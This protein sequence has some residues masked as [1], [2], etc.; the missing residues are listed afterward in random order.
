MASMTVEEREAF[1][2]EVRVGVLAIEHAGQGPLAV[3]IWYLVKD[4]AVLLLMDEQSLKARLVRAAGQATLTVQQE[5]P[6]YKYVSVEGP[7]T[8]EP[9]AKD[10]RLELATRYLGPA[11]GAKYASGPDSPSSIVARLTPQKWRTTDYSKSGS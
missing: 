11:A 10:L 1:L 7:V 5:T 2:A 8:L 3:P 9:P 4:G 6:P